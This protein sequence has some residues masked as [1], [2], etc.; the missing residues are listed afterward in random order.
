MIA[1]NSRSHFHKFVALQK[2]AKVYKIN[3]HIIRDQ[4][5][6]TISQLKEIDLPLI[7]EAICCSK[8]EDNEASRIGLIH[9]LRKQKIGKNLREA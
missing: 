8:F 4:Y 7:N 3:Y 9:V 6:I 2:I 1:F 5:I